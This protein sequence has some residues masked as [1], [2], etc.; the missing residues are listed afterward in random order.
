MIYTIKGGI[1]V[2]FTEKQD[3]WAKKRWGIVPGTVFSPEDTLK[4]AHLYMMSSSPSPD[5][6]SNKR[7]AIEI[8]YKK[9]LRSRFMLQGLLGDS[10]RNKHLVRALM[11]ADM[12]F[13]GA[14]D[15]GMN[16][17][18]TPLFR[19]VAEKKLIHT[20]L[21]TLYQEMRSL[22]ASSGDTDCEPEQQISMEMIFEKQIECMK[23]RFSGVR[24]EC[25]AMIKLTLLDKLKE[26][27]VT[28]WDYQDVMKMLECKYYWNVD[29]TFCY[30]FLGKHIRGPK[31][32]NPINS[33]GD[34]SKVYHIPGFT[35]ELH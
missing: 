17:I 5:I 23:E 6:S 21:K 9:E 32:S 15:Y 28:G 12:D 35:P 3:A 34:G 1:E 7:Q 2:H 14:Y 26:A 13:E 24:D 22:R 18:F 16:I 27:K 11:K 4:S 29:E 25:N 33:S 31:R 30:Y 19:K 20:E 8:A 10:I